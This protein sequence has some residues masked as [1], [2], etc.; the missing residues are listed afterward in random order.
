MNWA[1]SKHS[2]NSGNPC[3]QGDP[4]PSQRNTRE[5]V[6]TRHGESKQTC[7]KC[8]TEKTLSEFYKK[9]RITGRL[10]STCKACRIVEAR[11]RTL[12]VTQDEYL[13]LYKKQEGRCGICERRLYS[14]RYKSFCVDHDHST[15]RIRGLLCH[16]C[17]RA[18]GMLKDDPIALQRAIDWVKV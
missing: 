3:T 4:E 17:N 12:G 7:S 1:D 6:E 11:E 14:K 16:N 10:D 8:N 15:G 2:V 9:D 5:G 13:A 18:I